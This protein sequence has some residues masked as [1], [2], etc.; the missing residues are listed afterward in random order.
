MAKEHEDLPELEELEELEPISDP[1]PA[2]AA[3]GGA[4]AGG[5]RRTRAG[6]GTPGE[7]RQLERAPLLLRKASKILIAGALFPFFSALREGFDGWL[8][9]YLGK[10]LAGLACWLL[11]QGF[12][13][14][15]GGQPVDAIK[16]LARHRLVVPILSGV[17]A[18]ASFAPAF[19]SEWLGSIAGEVA[20]LVLGGGTL[21]HIWSYEHGGKFNPIFPLMFLGPGIAGLL[22][23]FGAMGMFHT[24]PA[25]AGLGLA[26]SVVV[27]AG[28]LYAMLVM[29][30]SI[31]QAKVEGDLKR[32]Q[33]RQQ[34]KAE[35]DAQKAK[36]PPRPERPAR[37]AP[38]G[39]PAGPEQG[40]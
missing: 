1:P 13:A 38:P 9:L 32:E 22:N 11:Y 31:R 14:T 15:H 4:G 7:K 5:A 17:V 33:L 16:K 27:A 39:G 29:Y 28:G 35:R 24:D 10:A 37:P 30:Q 6:A 25:M 3:E 26:G 23:V 34:R 20:T 21:V 8:P 19:Q 2:A 36:R 40:G 18:L 12:M